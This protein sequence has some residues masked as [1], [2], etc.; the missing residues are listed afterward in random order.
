MTISTADSRNQAGLPASPSFAARLKAAEQAV[1]P[2]LESAHVL[3][4]ALASTP[5]SLDPEA[6]VHRRQWLE[7]E[8]RLFTRVCNELKLRTEHVVRAS[9]CL[10]AALDEAAMQM[11]WGKGEETGIDWQSNSLAVALGHDRQGGDRVF[12]LIDDAMESPRE[13]L[14]LIEL[15]QNILDLGFQGRYRFASEGATRLLNIRE[16]VHDVVMAGGLGFVSDIEPVRL[17]RQAVVDPWVRPATA[18]R[19]RGW[20]VTVLVVALLLAA[21]GYAAVS[22]WARS[23]QPASATPSLDTLTEQLGSSL[24]DELAAG[25]VDLSRDVAKNALTLRFNGMYGSGD[26]TVAPWW[27]S[28]MASIGRTIATSAP[29][30]HVRVAGYTDAVPAS[31]TL[32]GTNQALSEAR[33]QQ[34]AQILVA[35]G[36]PKERV[37]VAGQSDADPL[38]DNASK[39]GRARNRRVEVTVS[40]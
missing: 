17:P 19:S 25:N 37:S 29:A 39:G 5:A 10:C 9:Y 14:D 2:L 26:V 36:V 7:H 8:L 16:R 28:M 33:A 30:A 31:T 12:R 32:K 1:N 20:I 18:R 4:R 3:L 24:R 13:H 23:T 6:V 27:A 38:A 34:V 15:F 35:A 22:H 21:I 11:R 40:N